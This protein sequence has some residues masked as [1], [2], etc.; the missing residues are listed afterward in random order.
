MWTIIDFMYC[1]ILTRYYMDGLYSPYSHSLSWIL[2]SSPLNSRQPPT[3][4]SAGNMYTKTATMAHVNV[5]LFSLLT[6]SADQTRSLASTSSSQLGRTECKVLSEW[7]VCTQ[8]P[9]VV[10]T[11]VRKLQINRVDGNE[12]EHTAVICM[13]VQIQ[14]TA[15]THNAFH[16]HDMLGSI[17][18]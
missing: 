7:S 10:L 16:Y 18:N 15:T 2:C 9:G 13:Y 8:F 17:V 1:C 14:T 4:S 5:L 12:V 11:V 6:Y 3:L